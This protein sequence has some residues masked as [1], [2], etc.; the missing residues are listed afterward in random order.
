MSDRNYSYK[1]PA[2]EP[3]TSEEKAWLKENWKNEFHFLLAYGLKI[4][5]E[6]YRREGR[7]I[8]GALM[9][10]DRED[11][12]LEKEEAEASKSAS[13][14]VKDPSATTSKNKSGGTTATALFPSAAIVVSRSGVTKP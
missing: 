7:A 13:T 8:L 4:Y 3:H 11:Q 12:E 10:G 9:E 2:E 14:T 5:N 6:E 1:S